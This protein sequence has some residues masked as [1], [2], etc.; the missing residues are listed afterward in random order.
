MP[1]EING[2][3]IRTRGG[4]NH[5]QRSEDRYSPKKVST[6]AALKDSGPLWNCY[7]VKENRSAFVRNH[8]GLF[9]QRSFETEDLK[10]KQLARDDKLSRGLPWTV[11]RV[12]DG[13]TYDETQRKWI[14][15]TKIGKVNLHPDTQLITTTDAKAVHSYDPSNLLR[16]GNPFKAPTLKRQTSKTKT[17]H[18]DPDAILPGADV[19]PVDELG[20]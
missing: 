14:P 10:R 15:K 16:K 17:I 9:P 12:S 5:Q 19:E 18:V 20:E 11:D 4:S 6:T 2:R 7:D 3:P 13:M 8:L 1:R